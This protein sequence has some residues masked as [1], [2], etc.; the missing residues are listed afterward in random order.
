[1]GP[2]LAQVAVADGFARSR[3]DLV[4]RLEKGFEALRRHPNAFDIDNDAAEDNAKA[5]ADEAKAQGV[6]LDRPKNGAW[7]SDET[8]VVSGSIEGP[9]QPAVPKTHTID[10]LV[11]LLDDRKQRVPAR[12]T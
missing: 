7:A 1:M 6:E 4:V 3:R 12:S 8:S 11:A 10:E 9:P 5:I 2:E